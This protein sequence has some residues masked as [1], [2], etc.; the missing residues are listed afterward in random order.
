LVHADVPPH[1]RWEGGGTPPARLNA[2]PVHRPASLA[3]AGR[4]RGQPGA[5]VAR[6]VEKASASL[7]VEHGDRGR[8]P[9]AGAPLTER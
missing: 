8:T 1:G 5:L 3:D 6:R 4:A 9:E 2:K 7:E